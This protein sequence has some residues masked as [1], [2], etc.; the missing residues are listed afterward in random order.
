VCSS[1]IGT[2]K[3]KKE[4]Y[5]AAVK[6]TGAKQSEVM[7]V[8]HAKDEL[9]GAQKAGLKTIDYN[10][11]PGAKGDYHAEHFSDILIVVGELN[12]KRRHNR[13]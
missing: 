7:F 12:A 1:E 9:E 5:D 11:D 2:Y 4:A 8:G 3:P 10:I 13:H 6:A